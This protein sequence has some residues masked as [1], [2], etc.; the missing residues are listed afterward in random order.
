MQAGVDAQEIYYACHGW[1]TSDGKLIALLCSRSKPHL[2]KVAAAYYEQRDKP[3]LKRLRSETSGWYKTFMTYLVESP[4][5]ADVGV[6]TRP[7]R[8]RR[9]TSHAG[10]GGQFVVP[11]PAAPPPRGPFYPYMAPGHGG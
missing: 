4:E 7:I 10:P 5:N 1:G 11:L 9:D 3:L 8:H 2:Q 6:L